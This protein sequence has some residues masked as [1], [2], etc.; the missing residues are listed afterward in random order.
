MCSS[1]M[2]LC[3]CH[4]CVCLLCLP[5]APPT[6]PVG[7]MNCDSKGVK[8]V[9]GEVKVANGS[10]P[11]IIR[12]AW[13]DL[14]GKEA[15]VYRGDG[16]W[17]LKLRVLDSPASLPS[18][19]TGIM[20]SL[21]LVLCCCCCCC[22]SLGCAWL[23][24]NWGWVNWLLPVE[25]TFGEKGTGLVTDWGCCCFLISHCSCR[26]GAYASG[27]FGTIGLFD[28]GGDDS[29]VHKLLKLC[30]C[31]CCC[32]CCWCSCCCCLCCC[33]CSFRSCS[34][35][36]A[37]SSRFQVEFRKN[38]MVKNVRRI[39]STPANKKRGEKSA[40]KTLTIFHS[41]CKLL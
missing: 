33:R 31:C 15:P 39:N 40:S 1:L 41:F 7:E 23:G 27:G 29:R 22:C 16:G 3:V 9:D 11:V 20:I 25:E 2:Y 30:C 36:K 17:S 13:K 24:H 37:S 18:I 35:L 10:S 28:R 26:V 5:E 6:K 32:W 21:L 34:L 19:R 38:L 4:E 12:K 8:N 14:D